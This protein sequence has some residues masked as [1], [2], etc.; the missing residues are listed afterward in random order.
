MSIRNYVMEFELLYHKIKSFKF[1]K[2][3]NNANIS[4]QHKQLV[5]ASLT[6]LKDDNMKDQM[7]AFSV[8]INFS[9]IVQ[10]EQ[11]TKA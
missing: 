2:F 4:V 6:E 1:C 9:S 7:K 11:N 8:P 5:R 10:D 3:L